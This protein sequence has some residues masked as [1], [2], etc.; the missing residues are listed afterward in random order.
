MQQILIVALA[1]ASVVTLK[2][3][4]GSAVTSEMHVGFPL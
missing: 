4:D 3:V 2:R 1:L